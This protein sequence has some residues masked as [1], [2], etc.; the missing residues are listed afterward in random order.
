MLCV[1]QGHLPVLPA[2]MLFGVKFFLAELPE[3]FLLAKYQNNGRMNMLWDLFLNVF[4]IWL[5]AYLQYIVALSLNCKTW[6]K[7]SGFPSTRF[8]LTGVVAHSS[9][10][11]WCDSVRFVGRLVHTQLF[12]SAHKLSR[13]SRSVLPDGHTK[14]LWLYVES[15]CLF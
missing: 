15:Y 10:Q 9:S 2:S 13:A 4:I 12:R 6:V 3:L 1:T 8:W 14:N 5:H 11:N 7:H